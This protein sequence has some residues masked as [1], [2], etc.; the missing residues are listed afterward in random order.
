[1]ERKADHV[2][3][4]SCAGLESFDQVVFACHSDQTLALLTD[5]SAA[6]REILGAIRYQPNEVV[7]HTDAALMPRH[8]RA[9]ASW[10]ALLPASGAACTVSYSMNLLQG[11]S[12]PEPLIVTL[13]PGGLIDPAKVLRRLHYHHP[14]HSHSSVAAQAHK[15]QI[16]GKRGTWFAGAYWGWGFHEDGARA[17][18]WKWL[19]HWACHGTARTHCNDPRNGQTHWGWRH[20]VIAADES[21][22]PGPGQRRL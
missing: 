5:S 9:W 14:V 17:A 18:L 15:A 3:I 13:N 6:E 4:V 11:I 12:S 10:N 22:I 16:Q 1:M 19:A 21:A 2:E 7:L 8:P 20:D